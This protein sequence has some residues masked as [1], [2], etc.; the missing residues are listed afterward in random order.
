MG[1]SLFEHGAVPGIL[2]AIELVHHVLERK[3]EALDLAEAGG[4]FLCQ[5]WLFGFV[6]FCCLVLLRLYGLAFPTP[7]H[8]T[9]YKGPVIREFH[10]SGA[11]VEGRNPPHH[12]HLG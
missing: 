5:T 2:A 7:G 3:T 12:S 6:P 9:D 11:F 1:S 8:V 4:C 10:W